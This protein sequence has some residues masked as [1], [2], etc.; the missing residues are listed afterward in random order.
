[1]IIIQDNNQKDFLDKLKQAKKE[2]EVISI[3]YQ[4]SNCFFVAFIEVN[5]NG[6]PVNRASVS[7]RSGDE[8]ISNQGNK[9]NG[10]PRKAT[11]KP[12]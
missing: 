2:N 1:M 3:T 5:D 7:S 10:K 11:T 9:R 12:A 6:S 4:Y 8:T